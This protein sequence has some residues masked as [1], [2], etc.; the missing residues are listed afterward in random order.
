MLPILRAMVWE[1]SG[2]YSAVPESFRAAV[3]SACGGNVQDL[4]FER[5]LPV[6]TPHFLRGGFGIKA[7]SC[8]QHLKFLVLFIPT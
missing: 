7:F 5:A 8:C 4:P 6:G 3:S 1:L 2:G